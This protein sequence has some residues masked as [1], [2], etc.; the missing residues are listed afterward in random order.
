MTRV[1]PLSL[2]LGAHGFN[3]GRGHQKAARGRPAVLWQGAQNE[4]ETAFISSFGD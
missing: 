4:H 2:G 3:P 1:L